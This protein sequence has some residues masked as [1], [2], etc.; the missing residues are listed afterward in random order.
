MKNTVILFL[1]LICIPVSS[2]AY[3]SI[4]SLKSVLEN[5]DNVDGKIK[6]YLQLSTEYQHINLDTAKQFALEG[7]NL[8]S[9]MKS[10]SI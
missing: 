3:S 10:E 9:E 1:V 5:T 8:A 7:M 2:I 4:D 6:A